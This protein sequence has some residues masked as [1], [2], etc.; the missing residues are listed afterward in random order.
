VNE[1]LVNGDRRFKINDA[2]PANWH[3]PQADAPNPHSLVANFQIFQIF[4][5][6][7]AQAPYKIAETFTGRGLDSCWRVQLFSAGN[8]PKL[9][10]L[11]QPLRR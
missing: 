7:L 2:G 10:Q 4:S 5:P 8:W 11:A 1:Y 3:T 9:G 6:G